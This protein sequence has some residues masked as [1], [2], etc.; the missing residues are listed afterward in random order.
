MKPSRRAGFTL[1]E[2]LVVIAII[3]VLA[4]LLLPAVQSARAASRRA[5][6]QNNIRQVGLGLLGFMNTYNRFPSAGVFIEN[7][8]ADRADPTD[9]KGP[10][11]IWLSIYKPTQSLSTEWMYNWVV[12]ILPFIDNA[13]LYNGWNKTLPYLSNVQSNVGAPS[14]LSI[15]STPIE[16]LKCP[17]DR[18][19]LPNTGNLS[20]VVNGGFARWHAAPLG[21][22]TGPTD[23]Y[24]QNAGGLLQWAP[25][26]F[27][28]QQQVLHKM[29]V[30]FLSTTDNSWPWDN[31]VNGPANFEDGMST[32]LLVSENVLAGASIGAPAS[33]GVP[34]NWACPLPN[35]C[36]FV[37]SDA[38]CPNLECMASQLAPTGPGIDGVGWLL[39]NQPG[40]NENI[41]F[42]SKNL[43]IKGSS[44]HIN[45]G[46]TGGFNAVFCDGS[47][48]FIRE[49]INGIVFSKIMTPAGSKLPLYCRQQPVNQD[50]IQ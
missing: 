49:T 13:E 41:N 6:C 27:A 28:N 12:E 50:A 1:I 25:P 22:I 15:S 42:G 7:P 38:V 35:F 44:P 26:G 47:T 9:P 20:Y 36:T 5:K 17:D 24:A 16:I 37:A 40:T 10:S 8:D 43:S 45:S 14:N 23:G 11:W 31:I 30:M 48:K 33:A 3:G 29:G 19:T 4:G 39:A 21:W 46:H 2:L 32:T 18:N 34:T